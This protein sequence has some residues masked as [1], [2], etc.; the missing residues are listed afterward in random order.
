MYKLT[1]AAYQ[2]YKKFYTDRDYEQL[3]L[4]R[5]L[6]DEFEVSSAIYPGCYIQSHPPSFPP[7][8][9]Y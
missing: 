8:G 5:L 4:F 7:R 2:A 3:D 1:N 9:L 6:R